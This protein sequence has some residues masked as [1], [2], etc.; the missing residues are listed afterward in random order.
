MKSF[1]TTH[2]YFFQDFCPFCQSDKYEKKYKTSSL[3]DK[4]KEKNKKTIE[5]YKDK[6]AKLIEKFQK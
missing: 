4:Q 3:T 1:C 2:H 5:S 6:L